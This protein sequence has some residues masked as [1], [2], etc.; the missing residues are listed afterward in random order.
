MSCLGVL[1][2]GIGGIDVVA[3]LRASGM[4]G[5]VLYVSDAGAVPYGKQSDAAL[6]ERI[7]ALLV[8]MAEQ[9]CDEAVLAC[10]AASTV[11]PALGDVPL[12][13]VVGVI[14]PGITATRSAGVREVA[15]LGGQR[16]VASGLYSAGL[17]PHG[18]TVH[19]VVAQPLSALIEQGICDGPT[20]E[21]TLAEI[22]APIRAATAVI[23]ACTHYLAAE[24]ALRRALPRLRTIIDPAQALV[25]QHFAPAPPS[26]PDRFWTTGDPEASRRAAKAAFG[27]D[28][29]FRAAGAQLPSA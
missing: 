1:D 28:A 13:R 11:L 10:N 27:F 2:W 9:G 20:L 5:P 22:V 23:S 18:V 19:E 6:R 26:G 7:Q 24:P 21:A 15:V 12:R 25:D 8:A 17:T 4:H 14:E 29:P 16:T 3:K